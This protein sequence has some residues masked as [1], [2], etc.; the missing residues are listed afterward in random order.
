MKLSVVI[1]V[2]NSSECLVELMRRFDKVLSG[3]DHDSELIFIDDC[4]PDESWQVLQK[5][6][7]E[8]SNVTAVQLMRNFG[9]AKAT[10]CGLALTTGEYVITMDDDLQHPPEEVPKL[11]QYME[12]HKGMDCAFGCFATKKHA[13][14]RNFASQI[15]RKVNGWSFRLPKDIHAS[16]FR[17]M[18]NSVAKSVSANQTS[19]PSITA[20]IYGTT[21]RVVSL[22]VQHNARY[23]GRSNY[24]LSKQFRLAFDNICNVSMLPLQ[25]VSVFGMG[26]CGCSLIYTLV[27]L[28]RSVMGNI[29]VPGWTTLTI[30]VAFFS[31]IILLSLGV[32]GEY[33]VRVLREVR[34]EPQFV[35]RQTI[36]GAPKEN[37]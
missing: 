28:V 20:L 4:S 16:T 8:Y 3:L 19:C 21:Q 13:R 6:V 33:L 14:Y 36:S 7:G 30:L 2:Y 5:L 18:R 12:E 31:G 26:M 11:I 1:P 34:G 37:D 25:A 27:I 29:A 22:P 23:A 17:I 35:V 32:I 24:T 15:I 9:Q 10:L